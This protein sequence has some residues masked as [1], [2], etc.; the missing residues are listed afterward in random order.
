MSS[1]G[2]IIHVHVGQAGVQ[3][4]N[5]CWELYCL[6]HGINQH[7]RLYNYSLDDSFQTFFAYSNCS[8]MVPRLVMVDSEPTVIDEV[9]TGAYGNLF[10]PQTLINGKE[11]SGSN[12]A[13]G[14]NT[15]GTELIDITMDS[16]RDVAESCP[17]LKGFLVFRSIGGGTGSGLGN[18]IMEEISNDYGKMTKMDFIIFPSPSITPLIVEPYNSLL[19]THIGMDFS[20]CTFILDNEA[21]YDI[22]ETKLG[23]YSP[24]YTNLNRII[25]QV[26][27][28][29]TASQRFYGSLNVSFT[30][31]QT[32]LVPFPRI[33]FPLVSYS[34]LI[35]MNNACYAVIS[36]ENMTFDCFHSCSQFIRCNP[37]RGK[38]MSCVLLYRGNVESSEINSSI[39][40]MKSRGCLN[41]VD[42]S[43]TGF[44]IGLNSM[45]P[46]AVYGGDIGP[47]DRAMMALTNNTAVKIAWCR[48]LSK[49]NQL[50]NRRAFLH[51]FMSE[52]LEESTFRE[53]SED[54]CSL[55]SDY[56]EVEGL[57]SNGESAGAEAE[58][59]PSSRQQRFN[60]YNGDDENDTKCVRKRTNGCC[61]KTKISKSNAE[62]RFNFNQDSSRDFSQGCVFSEH[63]S[64]EDYLI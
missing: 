43:P 39:K 10:K 40:I 35:S 26:I 4:A 53:A 61:L 7:G 28:T 11:D 27:S 58:V 44:K 14:Y 17:N 50:F 41:F 13:R 20:D 59:G 52:G 56:Q 18:R 37:A 48:M 38:Y 15:L 42:W 33:H 19:A 45:P 55:I 63:N 62:S 2:E 16:L 5:A 51:H 31:F 32:N 36:T 34:P 9:R 8:K 30:E 60:L 46:C 12:F 49:Y 57:S 1:N 54:I 3:I 64:E 6:E 21:L 29:M 22:C 24:T 23:V 47:T 25:A